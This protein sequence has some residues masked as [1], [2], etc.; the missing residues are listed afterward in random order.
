MTRKR[1]GS[2][3]TATLLAALLFCAWQPLGVL[4]AE[5]AAAQPPA[6]AKESD[7]RD[8]S[9]A[10]KADT[11]QGDPQGDPQGDGGDSPE[12]FVPT[13]EISEDFA[14]SFPVDI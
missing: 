4:A 2:R 3:G 9:E 7:R 8:D 14:V 13:E 6:G 5:G 12:I 11:A 10:A 1:S